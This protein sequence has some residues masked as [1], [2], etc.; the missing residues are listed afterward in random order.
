MLLLLHN[1]DEDAVSV[2]LVMSRSTVAAGT[3]RKA[4]LRSSLPCTLYCDCNLRAVY[5][6]VFASVS[7]SAMAPPPKYF[8]CFSR[9]I[10]YVI[11]Q[12]K[13]LGGG[14]IADGETDAK[15]ASVDGP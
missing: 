5:N 6:H 1:D 13:K 9:A 2:W 11:A 10:T 15:N 3:A 8:L 12:R 14:A 4:R 7:P